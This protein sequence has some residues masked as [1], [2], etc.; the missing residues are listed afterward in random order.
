M[1]NSWWITPGGRWWIG[2]NGERLR[3]IAGGDGPVVEE[4]PVEVP[5]VEPPPEPTPPTAEEETA[6]LREE[7]ARLRGE[8]TALREPR[9]AEPP[10]RDAPPPADPQVVEF[11]AIEASFAK[12]EITDAERVMR[13]GALGAEA[14][15][16]RRAKRDTAA[17]VQTRDEQVRARSGQKVAV[18]LKKYPG[19]SD[20]SG[21]EM[22]RVLP[23]LGDIANE[24]GLDAA[25]PRAQALALERTFGPIDRSPHVDT[26]EFE[27]RRH[28]GS[29]GGGG[30]F[31]EE[32]A[33]PPKAKSKGERLWEMCTSETQEFFLHSARQRGEPDPKAAA[34]R[35]LDVGGD[36]HQMRKQGRFR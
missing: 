30:T 29:G 16:D 34:I 12:G 1:D 28:P 15:L 4:P 31:G 24:F 22:Q 27:R 36:E 13:L 7:N 5:P 3:V 21:P 20:G 2:P 11:Q 25:D 8:N 18:Y 23:H 6:R 10:R 9:P 33:S 19:L 32:P 17:A 26:R 14:A 35:S